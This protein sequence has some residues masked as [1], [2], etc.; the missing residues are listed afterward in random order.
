MKRKCVGIW[1]CNKCQKVIA[2]GA[3]LPRYILREY[4]VKHETQTLA[5]LYITLSGAR[6][7]TEIEHGHS[8]VSVT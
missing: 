3:W 4:S 1:H 5:E 7:R 8:S 6:S 2:G